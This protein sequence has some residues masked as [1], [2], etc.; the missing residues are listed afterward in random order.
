MRGRLS[1]ESFEDFRKEVLQ[2]R[3]GPLTSPVDDI[4]D[5]LFQTDV[6][7]DASDT[8]LWDEQEE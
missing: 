8:A 7:D 3:A 5:D 2:H 6:E 1:F 4:V